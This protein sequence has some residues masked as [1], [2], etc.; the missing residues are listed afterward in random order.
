[1]M[2]QEA[3]FKNRRSMARIPGAVKKVWNQKTTV[4]INLYNYRYQL[5]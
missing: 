4:I 3:F 2:T 5:L 1:M